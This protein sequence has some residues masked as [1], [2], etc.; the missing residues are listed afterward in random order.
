[1]TV[2]AVT[3]RSFPRSAGRTH[4]LV[5]TH[6]LDLR[7]ADNDRPLSARETTAF[8]AGCEALIVGTDEVTQEVLDTESLRAVV[9]YG[10]G[11]DNIDLDAARRLGVPVEATGPTNAR[12]VAEL[13]IALMLA[14]ARGIPAHDRS[15]RAGSWSRRTGLELNGKRLGVVGAGQVGREVAHLAAALGMDVLVHDP[16]VDAGFPHG[17]LDELLQ[18]SHV[19]SLHL[20]LT[21]ET[22]GLLDKQR[23]AAMRDGALLINTARG[24]LVDEDALAD[25]LRRG[26]LGGAAFDSFSTEPPEGSP[27]LDIDRFIASPH[28]GATTHEAIARTATKALEIV[29]RLVSPGAK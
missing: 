7:F 21:S 26:R 19:V 16:Y 28:A 15:V 11:L 27:L 8:V 4:D 18:T 14:L 25:E 23:L 12:S 2:V 20:P 29:V 10:S 5:R 9:K 24:G 1:M 13:A 17:S 22:L 6:D 3:P